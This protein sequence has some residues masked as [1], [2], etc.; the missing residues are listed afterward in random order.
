MIYGKALNGSQRC[1]EKAILSMKSIDTRTKWNFVEAKK[2]DKI[3]IVSFFHLGMDKTTVM[4]DRYALIHSRVQI[5]I[6]V[7][8][9]T[10]FTPN[11]TRVGT[12]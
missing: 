11:Q 1:D 2:K 9:T 10:I 12:L 8:N 3:V 7:I 5:T 6:V 4:C